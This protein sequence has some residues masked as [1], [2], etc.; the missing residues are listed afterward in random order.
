MIEYLSKEGISILW[1]KIKS[2]FL[3]KDAKY[4][5]AEIDNITGEIDFFYID[6]NLNTPNKRIITNTSSPVLTKLR[7]GSHRYSGHYKDSVMY[8]CQLLDSNTSLFF[9]GTTNSS[10]YINGRLDCDV[11]M[12]LPEFW[13]KVSE[14]SVDK[15]ILGISTSPIEGWNHW[16]GNHLIGVYEAYSSTRNTSDTGFKTGYN[17]ISIDGELHS[18]SGVVS[19]GAICQDSFKIQARNRGIGF[20]LVTWEEHCIMASLFFMWYGTTNSQ[21]KCGSGTDEYRKSCGRT[22]NLGMKD[23]DSETEGSINFWGL[24]NWWGNKA[25]YIDNIYSYL[26]DNTL[27][28]EIWDIEGTK[29]RILKLSSSQPFSSGYKCILG[30]NLDYLPSENSG[31]S[32]SHGYCDEIKVSGEEKQ[33]HMIGTRQE[34][35]PGYI[36]KR[37]GR[38]IDISGGILYLDMSYLQGSSSDYTGSRLSFHGNIEELSVADYISIVQ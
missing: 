31:Y 36:G 28:S 17:S 26:E 20:S 19:S 34:S 32:D 14:V 25:E 8:I 27:K 7:L 24:E 35:R 10:N 15:W 30:E 33:I 9:D 6:Q 2:K 38:N 3:D 22:N 18:W 16:D 5:K 21:E 11:W 1:S 12:R 29:S 37:S 13:W 4:T 23:T